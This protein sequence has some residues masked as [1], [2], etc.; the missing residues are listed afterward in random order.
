MAVI[1]N[2]EPAIDALDNVRLARG[3]PR[4]TGSNSGLID[5]IFKERKRELI[6]EGWNWYDQVRYNR[7]KRNNTAFNKLISTNGIFWPI[8]ED[9]LSRNSLLVQNEFW[10]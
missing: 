1:G 3:L 8:A 2:T 5:A 4:Y 6:G 9:V 10:R 7:I